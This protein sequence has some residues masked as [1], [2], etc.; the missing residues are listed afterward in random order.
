MD[1]YLLPG[2]MILPDAA[3]L[4]RSR[5]GFVGSPDATKDGMP[6][7]AYRWLEVTGPLHPPE[8]RFADGYFART[9]DPAPM[10]REFMKAAYRRPPTEAEVG[11]YLK[12]VKDGLAASVGFTE[13]MIAGYTAVLCSPGFLYL[14]EEPGLLSSNALAS[15]LSYFLWN[16]PPDPT[17]R[18][19][20]LRRPTVLK[21]ETERLMNSP[22]V[23]DF[24]S[25]FLDFWL[26]LRKLGDNT[27]DQ[28]LYPEYYLDD[29]LTE[30]ATKETQ[31]FIGH[32]LEK[33][34]PASNIVDSKFTFLNSHL[35]R[36][37]DLPA[38]GG[39]GMR[40]V[41]LPANSKRG[42]LL[43]QASVLK[44]TANGTTTSP[45]LRGVWIMERILGDPPPPPPPGTPAVEPDTRG[46]TTIREQ[47]D[48]HRSNASCA[49]CHRKIDPP[50]FALESFDVF[51]KWRTRYRSIGEGEPVHGLGKN[52]HAFTFRLSQTVDASGQMAT[53]EQFQDVVE[54]KRL[55]LKDERQIARNLVQQLIAYSTGA[56]VG[57]A[58][59]AEVERILDVSAKDHFGVR[60]L[61]HQ[62]IQSKLFSSK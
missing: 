25:A 48:K 16:A 41:E 52:G 45:V 32:L 17:L 61:I 44:V 59:R 2:E 40:Y 56:P 31:L 50:G 49:S 19:L 51:G 22:R 46:A 13:A 7:V 35:A 57:F 53:G 3:R 10:L 1:V 62:V 27:P 43:T 28:T 24:L 6:G 12:I 47:L 36:H 11:R 33:N 18:G 26:D 30:S 8:S 29:L 9:D 14:E 15:R 38:V 37:Y 21:A 42:G 23:K 60:T 58:D 20:D 4:F 54:F 55:L 5:P 34:L 39:S